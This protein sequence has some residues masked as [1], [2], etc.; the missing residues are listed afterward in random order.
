MGQTVDDVKRKD[1]ALKYDDPDYDF[2]ETLSEQAKGRTGGV[3]LNT[4]PSN[5]GVD[6]RTI[7][8]WSIYDGYKKSGQIGKAYIDGKRSNTMTI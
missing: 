8:G 2:L 5:W 6:E 3:V 7:V 4:H 1:Q